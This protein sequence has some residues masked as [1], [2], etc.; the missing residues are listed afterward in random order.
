LQTESETIV[1]KIMGRFSTTVPYYERC[2]QPYP[3]EFFHGVAGLLRLDGT[4][5]LVDVGCG[6]AMLASGFAP[7]VRSVDGVDPEPAMIAAAREAAGRARLRLA[8]HECRIEDL[9]HSVGPFEVALIGRAL[10]WMEP[11]ATSAALDRIL[12][13]GG[14]IAVCGSSSVEDQ[15]PWLGPY[16]A[17]RQSLRADK[18]EASYR[19][20]PAA[21]FSGS[22]FSVR[23]QFSVRKEL[24]VS[25][26]VLAGRL[27]SM[28]ITSP[29]VLG[30]R[31]SRVAGEVRE[32]LAPYLRPDG[33]LG[34]VIEA[35][36]TILR[37]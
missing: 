1:L 20:D 16:N 31:A 27:L 3:E 33:T 18:D 26:D 25:A 36:A 23:E 9:P 14:A 29:A 2:R 12:T 37:R 11:R 32:A 7:H 22:A 28:S 10:H 5:A 6:P 15:N 35:K 4:Q 19:V 8:L 17:L 13:P 34:E 21:Y 24:T 30:A